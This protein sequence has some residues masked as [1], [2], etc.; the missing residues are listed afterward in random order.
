MGRF[1][2]QLQ[3]LGEEY[4]IRD[5]DYISSEIQDKIFNEAIE[6][7]V[8]RDD[9]IFKPHMDIETFPEEREKILKSIPILPNSKN[10]KICCSWHGT[11]SNVSKLIIKNGFSSLAKLDEGWFGKGIYFS[12]FP[13]YSIKYTTSVEDP[14]LILCY[15]VLE[16]PF[17]VVFGERERFKGKPNYTTTVK[18]TTVFY[19][20]HYV[21]IKDFLPPPIGEKGDSDE[22]VIFQE[23]HILPKWIIHLEKKK[24]SSSNIQVQKSDGIDINRLV[25]DNSEMDVNR[26]D[27][28]NSEMDVNRLDKDNSE[29]DI[30]RLDKDN[31]EMDINRLEIH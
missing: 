20:S 29:M 23:N 30:N 22:L 3:C 4:L 2:Q 6:K 28:D 26:L 17:P 27:K 19:G 7:I 14:C 21:P 16:N 31:S 13:Q 12:N 25:K 18:Q 5:I 9:S 24:S 10:I 15:T 8:R 1:T 11:S